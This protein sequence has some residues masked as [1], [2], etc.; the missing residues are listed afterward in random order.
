MATILVTG[1]TGTLGRPTVAQL[2]EAGHEVRVFSR[3]SGAGLVTG[4]LVTNNGLR[5]ALAGVNTVIHLATAGNGSDIAAAHNLFPAARRAGVTHLVLISIVGIEQIPLPYYT[6]KV[7][8][9]ADL[10]K[11]GLKYTILRATQFHTLVAG[12]FAAQRR[13]PVLFSPRMP[14]QP[15]DP[16]EVAARL[17]ELA[18]G[19]PCGRVPDIGG[20]EQNFVTHFGA[21]W[22]KAAGM[23][24]RIVSV[25]LPGTTFAGYATGKALVPG[26]RYGHTT[27]SEYFAEHRPEQR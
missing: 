14:V 26:P 6:D 24:R 19:A 3:R 11:S 18:A 2:R 12:I 23:K 20:P 9:E 13:L 22:V 10:V 25:R 21:Q 4:D 27:F 5:D 15:I 16:R 7:T 8:I 17:V 1:G